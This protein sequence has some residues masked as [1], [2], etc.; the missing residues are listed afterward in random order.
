MRNLNHR[1]NVSNTSTQTL[2]EENYKKSSVK[3]TLIRTLKVT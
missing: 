2:L 3:K 1:L